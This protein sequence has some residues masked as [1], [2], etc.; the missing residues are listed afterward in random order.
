MYDVIVVGAGPGGGI[1]AYYLAK[2]G[3][4]VLILERKKLPRFK[5][6]GGAVPQ[7]FLDLLP[8]DLSAGV[9]GKCDKLR[10]YYNLAD[11]YDTPLGSD[12]AMVNRTKFDYA[13]VQEATKAGAE[14]SDENGVTSVL[15]ESDKIIVSANNG[16]YECKYLI[17]ADG[18]PSTIANSAGLCQGRNYWS[19]IDVEIPK[20]DPDESTLI[21]NYGNLKIGYS[22]SFPKSDS[23]S[24]GIGG[25]EAHRLVDELK[26]WLAFLGYKGP[27]DYRIYPHAV[28]EV[29]VGE[30]VHSGNILLVGD[31]AGLVNPLIGEGIRYAMMSG[32]VAAE[33]IISKKVD[34]Y[35]AMV[36]RKITAAFKPALFARR[37]AIKWPEFYYRWWVKN[38]VASVLLKDMFKRASF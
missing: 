29:I 9:T 35:S 4:K 15:P 25:G 24:V 37:I 28:P 27:A 17:G 3:L 31:A 6:C 22:W 34:K 33:A 21:L 16:T 36:Y 26:K 19:S 18:C 13:I 23:F 1:A 14:L 8:F 38:P 2:A 12:M 30:K 32:K 7:S 20:L 10:I 11:P 5:P